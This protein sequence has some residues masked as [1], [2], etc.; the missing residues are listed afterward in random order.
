VPLRHNVKILR[1]SGFG[2]A[3]YIAVPY[4][5]DYSGLVDAHYA[6]PAEFLNI[7]SVRER[8]YVGPCRPDLDYV[9]AIEQL[10]FHREEI[11]NLVWNFEYLDQKVKKSLV[12][13]LEEYFDKA[14][15]QKSLL[16]GF[17][18]TCL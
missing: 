2:T 9:L 3:G 6:L 1:L 16:F 13:Y 15:H 17:Q 8:Y 18:R 14:A 11:L 4:D 7:I 12:A 10:N 5:F